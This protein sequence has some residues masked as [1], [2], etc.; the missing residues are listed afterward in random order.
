M[1]RE[2]IELPCLFVPEEQM[3]LFEMDLPYE[4]EPRPVTF[5][6]INAFT[7]YVD[8]K[9]NN[10][11]EIVTG[12][13]EYICTHNYEHVKKLLERKNMVNYED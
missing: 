3:A 6:V 11:T 5:V 2:P 8:P 13:V 4:S 10:Y 1:L 9:G 7:P 12:G